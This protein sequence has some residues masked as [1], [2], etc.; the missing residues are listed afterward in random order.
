MVASTVTVTHAE[1]CWALKFVLSECS[2]SSFEGI[3]QLLQVMFPDSEV[4]ESF[5]YAKAKS[6]YI[7]TYGLAPYF[8][9]CLQDEV[10]LVPIMLYNMMKI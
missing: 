3:G 2:K 9:Q 7:I 1:I 10:K 4:A 5:S 8:F 6:R